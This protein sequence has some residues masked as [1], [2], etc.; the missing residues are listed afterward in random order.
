VITSNKRENIRANRT[1]EM[2]TNTTPSKIVITL[3]MIT[4]KTMRNADDDGV[5]YCSCVACVLVAVGGWVPT[6][7][8]ASIVRDDMN[9]LTSL[10]PSSESLST[11]GGRR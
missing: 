8:S 10:M 11:K 5:T 2:V 9:A 3:M 6:T 1:K 4:T 7:V